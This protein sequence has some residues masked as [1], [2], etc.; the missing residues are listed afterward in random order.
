MKVSQQ[1]NVMLS[2]IDKSR[3]LNS[4]G[5]TTMTN[6]AISNV[7]ILIDHGLISDTK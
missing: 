3:S 7:A 4:A 5:W 1:N 2:L 6:V